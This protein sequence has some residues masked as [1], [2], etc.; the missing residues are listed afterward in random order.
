MSRLEEIRAII[1]KVGSSIKL[2]E[3][4][5]QAE[6]SNL[7]SSFSNLEGYLREYVQE[8]TKKQILEIINKLRKNES[9]SPEELKYVELW[10]VGD[11]E[12][13]TKL[14]N[15]FADWIDEFNRIINEV[16]I[17]TEKDL[18]LNLEICNRLRALSKDAVRN[19]SDINY[20]IEQR[21]RITKFKQSIAQIDNEERETLIEILS[22]K[23]NSD[24]F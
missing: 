22:G 21:E 13:Y 7:A 14:E 9:L 11:A 3:S 16:K 5:T 1:A 4:A 6:V 12:Y 18:P 24:T 2:L 8:I 19:I 10:L 20:F 15:N 17:I 23:L